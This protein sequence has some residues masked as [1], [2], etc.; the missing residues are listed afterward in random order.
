MKIKIDGKKFK[1]GRKISEIL[2]DVKVNRE[3]VIVARNGT[4]T[5]ESE[6]V[7]NGDV[8]EVITVISGG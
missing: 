2:R 3:T 6:K 4:I 5:P 8:L 1:S 7:R